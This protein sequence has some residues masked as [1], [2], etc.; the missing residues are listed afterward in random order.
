MT[1]TKSPA[2]VVEN[3]AKGLCDASAHLVAE[4]EPG[5]VLYSGGL[6]SS[7]AAYL[8]ARSAPVT[9]LAIGF[10]NAADL[11]AAESGARAL[12]LPLTSRILDGPSVDASL[13]RWRGSLA[14][15]EGSDFSVT[16]GLALALETARTRGIACGQGADEL[17]LGYAHYRGLTSVAAA[18]R[19]SSDLRHVIEVSWPAARAI[20][21]ELGCSLESPF[22]DERFR[23]EATE[24]PIELRMPDGEPKRL[25]RDI[26]R[27]VGLPA[28]LASR[29]KRAFQYG[30]GIQTHLR[31][32][33]AKKPRAGLNP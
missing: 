10:S 13:E 5:T 25:L 26:A 7:L 21:R 15:L 24:T 29:R 3:L 19:S 11:A 12:G 14:G 16:L 18:T 8:L 4:G 17:F 27:Q 28:D 9:L 20:A 6:D 22:L 1:E 23:R 2:L 30:S 31:G 33:R 32:R